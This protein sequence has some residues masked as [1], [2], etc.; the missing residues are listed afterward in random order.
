MRSIEGSAT[1]V[2]PVGAGL[3]QVTVALG[4]G[5]DEEV[6][7]GGVGDEHLFPVEDDAVAVGLRLHP[8]ARRSCAAEPASQSA[9]TPRSSPSASGRRKRSRWS[10]EPQSESARPTTVLVKSGEGASA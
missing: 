3:D 4:G 6:G 10:S 1:T 9:G 8:E 5:D 2:T 7:G